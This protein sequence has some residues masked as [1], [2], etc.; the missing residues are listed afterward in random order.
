MAGIRL[1]ARMQ[2]VA[3]MVEKPQN[4]VADIGCD[5]A[6]VSIYLKLNNIAKKIIAM[7]VRK[8]P[9]E[10][11][12]ANIAE[13]ELSDCIDTRLSDGFSELAPGEADVAVIAG[14][15]G[16]LMVDI[17]KRGK[18]HTDAGIELVLQPQSEPDKLRMYLYEIGYKIIDEVFLKDDGKYYTVIRAKLGMSGQETEKQEKKLAPAGSTLRKAELLYGPVLLRKKDA[19]LRSYISR[20]LEKNKELKERLLA[21]PTPK[22]LSRVKELSKEEK[23]MLCALRETEVKD[24]DFR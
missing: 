3:D 19:L 1:S 6:F 16:L 7:D 8:G 22:S 12:R 20:Q 9:L 24:N 17:L 14:M 11:A 10:I 13:Y 15:G 5:H 2:A 4:C 23:I 18:A 21:S